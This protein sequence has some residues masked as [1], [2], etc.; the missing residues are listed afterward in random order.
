MAGDTGGS[1]SGTGGCLG[2]TELV[3]AGLFTMGL[4]FTFGGPSIVA[5]A[6]ILVGILG[7]PVFVNRADGT[8]KRKGVKRGRR[9]LLRI[10]LGLA[11]AAI[12]VL[13]AAGSC[14]RPT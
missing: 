14:R 8:T 7:L 5:L 3:R 6:L 10:I 9:V 12:I 13:W 2:V 1:G 4:A 11:T